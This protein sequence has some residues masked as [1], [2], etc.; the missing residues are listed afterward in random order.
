MTIT[1]NAYVLYYW[2]FA[3]VFETIYS[4]ITFKQAWKK[5]KK[6]VEAHEYVMDMINAVKQMASAKFLWKKIF[7]PYGYFIGYLIFCI[8][9]PFLFI[10]SLVTLSKKLIGY[11]SKLEKDAEVEEKMA[12]EAQKEAKE[13]MANEGCCVDDEPEIE[14]TEDEPIIKPI[15]NATSSATLDFN[16]HEELYG[17]YVQMDD[18][19]E[20][21]HIWN[22]KLALKNK[23]RW[24][25]IEITK[26]QY[27]ANTTKENT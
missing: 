3:I 26:E 16:P 12:E 20:T 27:I 9:A 14:F 18:R 25:P 5:L 13:W 10:A 8:V 1:I 21:V 15:D 4:Y 17:K 7:S 11:K 6:T 22:E 24:T 23:G 2:A 19:F